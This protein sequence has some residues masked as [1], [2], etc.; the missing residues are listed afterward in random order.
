MQE[1]YAFQHHLDIRTSSASGG[2]FTAFVEA[3]KESWL[4][5]GVGNQN[6]AVYGATFDK[7]FNIIHKRAVGD[8]WHEFR[9]SKYG[10][11]DIHNI[12]LDIVDD[13]ESGNKVFF[14]GT[15]CQ[16]AVVKAQMERKGYCGPDIF[17]VDILCH[18]TPEKRVWDDYRNYIEDVYRGKITYFSFRSKIT[19][20][21]EPIMYAEFS[22]GKK[23]KDSKALR[24]YLD[25][26]FTYLPFRKC[27]YDCKFSKLERVSDITIGDF[28]GAEQIFGDVD[29]HKGISQIL[30]NSSFG[31][32]IFERINI[33][34]EFD[35]CKKNIGDEFLI[36][37]HNLT[38][39]TERPKGVDEFWKFYETHTYDEVIKRYLG[40]GIKY[41]LVF[42]IKRIMAYIG[43]KEKMKRL[44]KKVRK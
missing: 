36:Y 30:V 41:N 24:S 42:C 33:G 25:L 20:S 11:S 3:W 23:V 4:A 15:P 31:K 18:G 32:E 17:Y 9:G 16:V 37:Q 7:D 22:N 27:C 35:Y 21:H 28:W 26:Y 8:A 19:S 39:P 29:T 38:S 12:F 10:V 5:Q 43:I 13:L 40:F 34:K 6:L 44:I 2:A 1:V 14:S